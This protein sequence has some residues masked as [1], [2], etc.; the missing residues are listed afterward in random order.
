MNA[1][2]TEVAALADGIIWTL[3]NANFGSWFNERRYSLIYSDLISTGDADYL[4]TVQGFARRLAT[5]GIKGRELMMG[6]MNHVP[7]SEKQTT[8]LVIAHHDDLLADPTLLPL[9]TSLTKRLVADGVVHVGADGRVESIHAHIKAKNHYI[10]QLY[11]KYGAEDPPEQIATYRTN[12]HYVEA[13]E[14]HANR[15][16]HLL[17]YRDVRPLAVDEEGNDLYNEEEFLQ[18]LSHGAV[19][20]G[21][22]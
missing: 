2:E 18:Y 6:M 21:L 4:V 17:A 19:G 3:M 5:E 12:R 14:R 1:H 13:V 22:L 15:I 20:S 16:E 11:A 8:S 10:D 9:L 7:F